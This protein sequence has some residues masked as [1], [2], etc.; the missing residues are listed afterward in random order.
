MRIVATFDPS[1]KTS[2]TFNAAFASKQ[3]RI[4]VYNESNINLTLQWGSFTTYCPA[5]TAML[6]CIS[7]PNVNI[8]WSQQTTVTAQQVPISQVLVE[9][10]D[11]SEVIPGTFPAALSRMATVANLTSDATTTQI[12]QLLT[13]Q[14]NANM[15][16]G[17]LN[18][19]VAT[20]KTLYL[21]GL[22]ITA[23]IGA[24]AAHDTLTVTGFSSAVDPFNDGLAF[25]V[26]CGTTQLMP[27][28]SV[29]FPVPLPG[30]LSTQLVITGPTLSTAVVVLNIYYYVL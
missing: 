29:R 12:Q 11:N 17:T 13:L 2:D 19:G 24:A 22:D 8:N 9:A 27:P 6:Y 1:A 14:S 10:F 28:I 25:E 3:G 5:W 18:I 7:T 15:N 23:S 21:V 4:V 30:K 20:G 26:S 16:G